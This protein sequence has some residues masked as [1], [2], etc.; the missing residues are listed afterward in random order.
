MP[1]AGKV[2]IIFALPA[3]VFFIQNYR[4][5]GHTIFLLHQTLLK[6]FIDIFTTIHHS[7]F[8]DLFILQLLPGKPYSMTRETIEGS[9]LPTVETEANGDS[10][11]TMKR[12]LP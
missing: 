10:R 6:E 8:Y 5:A 1:V 12:V 7:G 11:S 9:P 2:V 3:E 4:N